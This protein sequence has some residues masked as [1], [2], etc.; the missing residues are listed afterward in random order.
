[1]NVLT[2][3]NT[4]LLI[5]ELLNEGVESTRKY[6]T[7]LFN[8]FIDNFNEFIISC[9]YENN[10]YKIEKFNMGNDNITSNMLCMNY[11][12]LSTKYMNRKL[13]STHCY[14]DLID[15]RMKFFQFGPNV[16]ANRLHQ[17]WLDNLLSREY[18]FKQLEI[19]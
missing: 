18:K 15:K 8:E 1:M 2:N 4:Q 12:W 5:D 11:K 6:L 17:E 14:I 16:E 9:G 13:Y 3:E 19:K 10:S 7:D